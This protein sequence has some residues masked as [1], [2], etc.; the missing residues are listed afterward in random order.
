MKYFSD[1]SKSNARVVAK[2]N[3]KEVFAADTAQEINAQETH[4]KSY[5]PDV[6]NRMYR[7]E[8]DILVLFEKLDK[9][10][11]SV[12]GISEKLD[13]WQIEV[14]FFNALYIESRMKYN[15]RKRNSC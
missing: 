2:Q 7:M 11:T 10:T 6:I 12:D 5:R 8:E 1:V 15:Q 9:M 14:S 13:K 3:S 4:Y